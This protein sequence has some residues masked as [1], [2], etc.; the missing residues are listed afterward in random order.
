LVLIHERS[1]DR[2]SN[3]E[4]YNTSLKNR[5]LRLTVATKIKLP[6]PSDKGALAF[7]LLYFNNLITHSQK[8]A[9]IYSE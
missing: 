1:D 9:T 6:K 7:S 2:H 5:H 4:Y 8:C 3:L